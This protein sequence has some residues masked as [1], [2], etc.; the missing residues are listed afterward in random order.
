MRLLSV[1]LPLLAV[2]TPCCLIAQEIQPVPAKRTT[3][4][5]TRMQSFGI[6]A[7]YSNSSSH[8]LEGKAQSRKLFESGF[9][10]SRLLFRWNNTNIQYDGE[11]LP[12]SF[13]S[14]PVEHVTVTQTAISPFTSKYTYVPIPACHGGTVSEPVGPP[15]DHASLETTTECSRRWTYSA[16]ALPA[17]FQWNFRT[18]HRLQ[19][20]LMAHAGVMYSTR[21]EPSEGGE[22]WNYAFDIGGGVEWF[23]SAHR[24]WRLEYRVHHLSNDEQYTTNS[25]ADNG[26]FRLSYIFGK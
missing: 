21:A 7:G 1:A 10:Y 20:I 12:V 14:D 9:S 15:S 23:Q 17:G 6:T 16:E 8:I 11:F 3:P 5:F 22:N 18:K 2:L 19:P 26:T 25:G 13:I 24:S 4:P